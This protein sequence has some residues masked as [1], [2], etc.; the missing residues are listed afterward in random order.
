MATKIVDAGSMQ[1][2]F[3]LTKQ[4][5]AV[6][7]ALG[8]GAHLTAEAIFERV[9]AQVPGVSLGTIYRTLDVLRVLGL[10]QIFSQPGEAARF[11]STIERHD[12]LLCSR[13]RELRN[14]RAEGIAQIA[15]A[16]GGEHGFR[17]LD[18][19]LTIVGIC[20]DCSR[21]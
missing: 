20:R 16:L 4:R 9:R 7:D 8:E 6:L 18:Y 5:A 12:H 10:V 3:R 11:E 19:A 15:V 14:V 17:E 13:C 1:A 2:R 21:N